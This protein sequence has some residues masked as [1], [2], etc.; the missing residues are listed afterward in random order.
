MPGLMDSVLKVALR[1]WKSDVHLR[2]ILH[3]KWT[4][5]YDS[6]GNLLKGIRGRIGA[7]AQGMTGHEIGVDLIEMQPGT[8][9]PLHVHDGDHVL[10]VES[11]TG[12]VHINGKNR[13]VKKGDSIFIAAEYPHGVVGPS[14]TAKNPLVIV[15]FGHPHTHVH[16]KRR[17]RHPRGHHNQ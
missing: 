17:M 13:R 16:S 10:Y 11:G 8:A 5:M 4:D 2:N 15:A 6:D 12:A 7:V 9:F 1:T 14:K 3:G